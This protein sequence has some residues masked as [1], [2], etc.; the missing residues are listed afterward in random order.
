METEECQLLALEYCA[1]SPNDY[2]CQH[3]VVY[4]E[5]P[6]KQRSELRLFSSS[7]PTA[8]F[9]I[10]DTCD[11][12]MGCT[13][14]N[15]GDTVFHMS[16]GQLIL[17][18]Y[19]YMPGTAKLCGDYATSKLH[20]ATLTITPGTCLFAHPGLC[21]C[22]LSSDE[23]CVLAAAEYCRMNPSDAGCAM[24]VPV[25][26]RSVGSAAV[27]LPGDGAMT[28]QGCSC[29]EA[30]SPYAAR[31]TAIYEQQFVQL[32]FT[33]AFPGLYHICSGATTRGHV[34]VKGACTGTTRAGICAGKPCDPSDET[35]NLFFADTCA[36]NADDDACD[37]IAFH[38][39]RP[40]FEDT[41][42]ALHVPDATAD[43]AFADATCG[44]CAHLETKGCKNTAISIIKIRADPDV[45]ELYVEFHSEKVGD[46]ELCMG[47]NLLVRLSL[48][49][50]CAFESGLGS[51]CT[52]PVCEEGESQACVEFTAQYCARTP[53]DP[54]CALFRPV[55]EV[56]A[57]TE[58]DFTL[59][60]VGSGFAFATVLPSGECITSD[61]ATPSAS[62]L[63][64]T[65]VV[66]SVVTLK[67]M[68]AA[69]QAK[70]CRDGVWVATIE[71]ISAPCAFSAIDVCDACKADMY[72]ATCQAAAAEHCATHTEDRACK[73]VSLLFK[74]PAAVVN[75][76][77]FYTTESAAGLRFSPA[78]CSCAEPCSEPSIAFNS[79]TL[80]ANLLSLSFFAAHAGTFRLCYHSGVQ[81]ATLIVESQAAC[82]FSPGG[83][84]DAAPCAEDPASEACQLISAD[85]CATTADPTC[86]FFSPVFRRLAVGQHSFEVPLSA[87]SAAVTLSET[88][89]KADETPGA[90][91]LVSIERS[92]GMATVTISA[93]AVGQV[94]VCSDGVVA[95]TVVL[96]APP[97]SFDLSD[98]Q[99]SP[100]VASACTADPTSET[101]Q[102]YIAEFCA[103][104]PGEKG[105]ELVRPYFKRNIGEW[106]T[107]AMHATAPGT[108]FATREE[109]SCAAPCGQSAVMLGEISY[110]V[111][112]PEILEVGIYLSTAGRYVLCA[113]EPIAAVD[114]VVPPGCGVDPFLCN[115]GCEDPMSEAC[116]MAL[117]VFCADRDSGVCALLV[118]VF[119]R[120]LAP[121]VNVP[122]ED[123]TYIGS[124]SCAEQTPEG[125]QVLPAPDGYGTNL[126]LSA[127]GEGKEFL[128]CK[129]T[130]TVGKL[131]LEA[132]PCMY[133]GEASPCKASVCIDAPYSE[134][135][136][137][138]HGK[139]CAETAD[140]GCSLLAPLFRRP[141][142]SYA[143]L[144]EGIAVGDSA[145]RLRDGCSCVN[146]CS[147][148]ELQVLV[149]D[150][151]GV[152]ASTP[153]TFGLCS[154]ST[155]LA[156]IEF[157]VDPQ[158][159][160]LE[161]AA[162]ASVCAVCR[163]DPEG[164]PCTRAGAAYCAQ[165]PTDQSCALFVPHYERTSGQVEVPVPKILSA[166]SV[167]RAMTCATDPA[168][169][170]QVASI[171]PGAV[172]TVRFAAQHEGT[173][174]IC[175]EGSV[176]ATV[177]VAGLECRLGG[178]EATSA[179]CRAAACDDPLSDACQMYTLAY[180]STTEDH[181]CSVVSPRFER[182]VGE[183]QEFILWSRHDAPELIK[184][185]SFIPETC[186]CTSTCME[187]AVE[188]RE[189]RSDHF[190]AATKVRFRARIEGTYRVCTGEAHHVATV[191]VKPKTTGCA[192]AAALTT[193]A[194]DV[195]ADPRSEVC[196]LAIAG[197][198]GA[199]PE[200]AACDLV[201]PVFTRTEGVVELRAS[202]NVE[203]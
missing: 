77:S 163:A 191:D 46:Y 202:A 31:V 15:V 147:A 60:G 161:F 175:V 101:C 151:V 57:D 138:L 108:V 103:T 81:A 122:V 43:I 130:V 19:A 157:E 72:S 54:G 58:V 16:E 141:L 55:Y 117:A 123:V 144:P 84:C 189:V 184:S 110:G 154:G 150:P 199:Y 129:N 35:C 83:P 92:S 134:T 17:S 125:L 11:C 2:G 145:T 162:G 119:R 107:I 140:A 14:S 187:N 65:V 114:A 6:L 42:L 21:Q 196:Q 136:Q 126:Y 29:A 174:T 50:V 78:K 102:L 76:V 165:Y 94:L 89:C 93:N 127:G 79:A 30:C 97:C 70:L 90:A 62:L 172:S 132:P 39:T 24:L 34:R 105:C 91:T 203:F 49:K 135:C 25:F 111:A 104:N 169:D 116:Q 112:G 194:D 185:V 12:D 186:S 197:H 143:F 20:I 170:D 1:S 59:S 168:D 109:C 73:E 152:Y 139:Y 66:D 13:T 80:D 131:L 63:D 166:A 75:T 64:E 5:R 53:S 98:D 10:P 68:G 86:D 192:L 146:P 18:F 52:E 178:F 71:F 47:G 133:D 69:G 56:A 201:T 158:A 74:R 195:C 28:L 40:A 61:E 48:E 51:P 180:C 45:E 182:I 159:C 115:A 36:T 87:G 4:F 160:S 100:C 190:A 148:P 38:F 96:D 82:V 88:S 179:P 85:Y 164:E 183:E 181:G 41:S 142:G 176:V 67:M 155:L 7:E 200:D 167:T 156:A 171:M 173:W 113:D 95:L 26:H 22:D 121:V 198:C 149:S 188:V 9:F 128:L 8:L 37:L 137:L 118:P 27:V 99:A 3:L 124:K 120:P 23:T 106:V 177:G 32:E 33:T 193:C 44:G 153:G